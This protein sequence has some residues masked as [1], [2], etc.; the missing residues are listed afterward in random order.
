L[1]KKTVSR[2]PDGPGVY[3]LKDARDKV[4]YVGKAKSLRGRVKSYVSPAAE[5]DPRRRRLVEAAV[6][7]EYTLTDSEVEALV[8]ENVLIKKHRP[9]YNVLYRDDKTYPYLKLT[10]QESYPRLLKTRRVL[11]DGALYFGPYVSAWA[12]NRVLKFAARHF[13]V[14]KCG[15]DTGKPGKPCFNYH[16][17]RCRGACGGMIDRESYRA[18]VREVRAVLEGNYNEVITDV[19]QEMWKASD[20]ERYEEAARLRDLLTAVKK[21]SQEQK[22]ERFGGRDGDVIGLVAAGERAYVQVFQVREGVIVGRR[23]FNG[24]LPVED[25]SPGEL[26]RT[27][28]TQHYVDGEVVPRN[29][30]LSVAPAEQ[31]ETGTYLSDL[32][33]SKVVLRVPQRGNTRRLVEMAVKNAW[34]MLRIRNGRKEILND[35]RGDRERWQGFLD[36]YGLV[37][38]PA[39]AECYDISNLQG[40]HTVASRVTFLDGYPEKNLYRRYRLLESG[41]PDDA[42]SLQKVFKR[43]VVHLVDGSEAEPDL[44]VVDGGVPQ[45]NAAR[46]VL[47]EAGLEAIPLVG[48]AKREETIYLPASS[49]QIKLPDTSPWLKFLQQLRNEAHRFAVSYHRKL[50]SKAGKRSFLDDIEGIGPARRKKLLSRYHSAAGL[51]QATPK[52]VSGLLRCSLLV[53]RRVIMAAKAH[54]AVRAR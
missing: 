44:I 38:P 50:R 23:A 25:D 18:V 16:I 9:R 26:L 15:G 31:A 2:L 46:S 28:L 10:V 45:V 3:F 47:D 14:G 24:T 33:G 21:M 36:R 39:L 4:I 41:R 6:S 52:E 5:S 32:R 54:Q 37:F 13:G 8:L 30:F 27:F 49:Y 43:R 40:R 22:I 11:K 17:G 1:N 53:A 42:G 34:E 20:E 51:A 48:L 35:D 7:V 19:E 12:V 29:L